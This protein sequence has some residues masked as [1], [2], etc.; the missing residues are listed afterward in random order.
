VPDVLLNRGQ[1][2]E[3]L[4]DLLTTTGA[5]STDCGFT[6]RNHHG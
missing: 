3:L 5:I 4:P 6:E 1:V 2:L